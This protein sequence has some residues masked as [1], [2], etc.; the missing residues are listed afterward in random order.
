MGTV[1][2]C[3]VA[4]AA[5]PP[6][7][8]WPLVDNVAAHNA[9]LARPIW[10]VAGTPDG[11]IIVGANDLLVFDGVEWNDIAV[12]SGYAFRSLALDA[13]GR[14]WVGGASQLG[15][16]ERGADGQW[17]FTSLLAKARAAGFAASE[18]IWHVSVTPEGIVFVASQQILRW[19]GDSFQVW[20]RP[21][22]PRLFAHTVAGRLHVHQP[23]TGLLQIHAGG[24]SVVRPAGQL[25]DGLLLWA[26]APAD[27]ADGDKHRPVGEGWLVGTND[28]AYRLTAAG[29]EPMPEL[30]RA[31]ARQLATCAVL[32]DDGVL[33]V[34][35]YQSGI[36]LATTGGRVLEI[37]DRRA[38][39]MDDRVNHLFVDGLGRLWAGLSLGLAR[40]ETSGE[41]ALFDGRNGITDGPLARVFSHGGNLFASTSRTL[42]RFAT[43]GARGGRAHRIA[44]LEALPPLN[45]FVWDTAVLGDEIIAAGFGGIWRMRVQR[46]TDAGRSDW[47]RQAWV[48]EHHVS[49]DV[50]RV[51]ASRY[52]SGTL[53]F[54]EGHALKALQRTERD[55]VP[56]I[57]IP[58][59][60]DTPVSLIEDSGGDV[61]VSL[62]LKGVRRYR[63]KDDI[64]GLPI[65]LRLVKN[66]EPGNGLPS[67]AV[68]PRL[69]LLGER[70]VA[71]TETEVLSTGG[72]EDDTFAP[73]PGFENW[74]GIAAASRND[75]TDA[76]WIAQ[77]HETGRAGVPVLFHVTL[78]GGTD[79]AQTPTPT[80]RVEPAEAQGLGSR[81][82]VTSLD[83]VGEPDGTNDRK[84]TPLWIGGA[85]RLLRVVPEAAALPPA[86]HLQ[87]V[88]ID[89]HPAAGINAR[90]TPPDG[91]PAAPPLAGASI[92]EFRMYSAASAAGEPV[93]YQT[94][95]LGAEN[96]WSPPQRSPDRTFA[97]LAPG[98][99]VF[100]ARAVDKWGRAGPEFSC[101]FAV[102]TPWFRTVYAIVGY[103]I[104]A[105]LLIALVV[106]WRMRQLHRRAA[107]LNRIVGERTRELAAAGAAKTEFL[108][109]ISHEIRNP[110]NGIIGLVS[111]LREVTPGGRSLELTR[112]LRA[113]AK[114]LARVFDDVLKFT[115]LE[116]GQVTLRE[117]P[118]SLDALVADTVA[119][120][121]AAFKRGGATIFIRREG[122]PHD[123][124]TGDAE[125]IE[126]ILANFIGNAL[127]YAPGL[128]VEIFVQCEPAGDDAMSVTLN[129]TDQGPGIPAG[130]QEYVFERFAR[131]ALAKRK[132]VSGTGLGLATC[133]ALASLLGGHVGVESPGL[134][135]AKDGR[136]GCTFFLTVRLKRDDASVVRSPGE[137]A[138]APP[139]PLHSAGKSARALIVEDQ[140]YNQIVVRRIA[141]NLGYAAAVARDGA[142]ALACISRNTYAVVL[143]DYELPDMDGDAVARRI[144]A[145]PGGAGVI[146]IGTTAHDGEHIRRQGAAAGMDG[147]A[148]KPFEQET[149]ALLLDEIRVRRRNSGATTGGFNFRVFGFVANDDP[150][151][152]EQSAHLYLELLEKEIAALGVAVAAHD[153]P[154]VSRCA[155]RLKSYAGMVDAAAL[156]DLAEHMQRTASSM[157]RD[158]LAAAHR[159]ICA[160]A[161][162]LDRGLREWLEREG[163]G[164]AQ[165]KTGATAF[166]GSTFYTDPQSKI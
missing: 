116:H 115:Q 70:V 29:S 54:V 25:P 159:E 93:H 33:A 15:F 104:A 119:L 77:N 142:D 164:G 113:C 122:D 105:L 88:L 156:R 21:C 43:P 90:D 69:S 95:L 82:I 145:Q 37:L 111:M 47:G 99:Y 13:S 165:G 134:R 154:A 150:A 12:S 83:I 24:P 162:E 112:S 124:F 136:P 130:E 45:T 50:F 123:R 89:G 132:R 28:G 152:T 107:E 17:R 68:R 85:A 6:V 4:P 118:F 39:L 8:G 78:D 131:G 64:D 129:V 149:I 137:R 101:R 100:Q 32:L 48:H 61:W 22:A 92:M 57:L 40:I 110:L 58:D 60:D 75:A 108:E 31:L 67:G 103:T 27:S 121:R 155:H 26:V 146:I 1:A 51:T 98:A 9:R 125:K 81:D 140:P 139:A 133:R 102:P 158:E 80:I 76:W 144:R 14:V 117:K 49:A 65:T 63:V 44:T 157:N 5:P 46:E 42:Y 16:I 109:R 148:Q 53:F 135:A 71:F 56:R 41:V 19:D 62:M 141:E 36:V 7:A 128:P 160:F 11:G 59:L 10:A 120:F 143:L 147:F 97:G 18:E 2:A 38:G 114:S 23:G 86:V 79:A 166:E 127:K 126:S 163:R 94:R 84:K 52:L 30:S 96:D 73:V 55:W 3:A 106:S 91:R 66:F 35:T 72:D 34:G 87:R 138:D 151:Q 153:G 161:G 20:T 74:T